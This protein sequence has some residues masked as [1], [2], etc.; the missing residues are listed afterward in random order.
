MKLFDY[1][2]SQFSQF[3]INFYKVF[4]LPNV[5]CVLYLGLYLRQP[6]FHHG[7]NKLTLKNFPSAQ[8]NRQDA[9][10]RLV[11]HLMNHYHQEKQILPVQ[12]RSK[13]V[14]VTFDMA[15]SQLVDLVSNS[16]S[17]VKRI[18]FCGY[19]LHEGII[20]PHF[21]VIFVLMN[22]FSISR[23]CIDILEE[24]RPFSIIVTKKAKAQ[25]TYN[26]LY[27]Q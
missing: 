13:P 9:E 16:I 10:F 25:L 8:E 17:L 2:F 26:R 11:R 7:K 18:S 21:F 12:N 22:C 5:P 20:N 4:V 14:V 3:G 15:F 19:W 1:P 27:F 6:S 23:L 24:N